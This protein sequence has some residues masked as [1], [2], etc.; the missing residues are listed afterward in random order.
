MLQARQAEPEIATQ[1]AKQRTSIP[2][3]F[4]RDVLSINQNRCHADALAYLEAG[5]RLVGT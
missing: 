2:D 4:L 1:L 3:D 5:K